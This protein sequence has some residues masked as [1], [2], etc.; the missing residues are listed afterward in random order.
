MKPQFLLI[1]L[2]LSTSPFLTGCGAHPD[3][4]AVYG[5]WHE[6]QK[7]SS[8]GYGCYKSRSVRRYGEIINDQTGLFGEKGMVCAVGDREGCETCMSMW[9]TV[10]SPN[11]C[12]EDFTESTECGDVD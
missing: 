5:E 1:F 4:Y 10:N 8:Y 3:G 9:M 12:F 2:L 6:D 7:M 11:E